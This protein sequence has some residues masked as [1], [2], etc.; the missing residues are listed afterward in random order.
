[1]AL[2][3]GAK[4]RLIE[5]L[6]V[7]RHL[8]PRAVEAIY[9]VEGGLHGAIGDQGTSFGP[10]QMHIGGAMPSGIRNPQQWANSRPGLKY[11]LDHIASVARGLRGRMAVTAIASKFERPADVQGEI[12]K[13]MSRYGHSP[14]HGLPEPQSFGGTHGLRAR[15]PEGNRA[16]LLQAVMAENAAFA[17][18][19]PADPST[20]TNAI[21]AAKLASTTGGSIVPPIDKKTGR[22]PSS[23]N[24]VV[25]QVL[26]QAHRQIG[27]P[28]VWGGESRKEGGFD[29]SGLIQ[30]AYAQAG[31][32]IPRTTY[33]Q[34]KVGKHVEWGH[35]KPGDLIFAEGGGHVVMYVGHGKVI[36]APHTGAVVRYQPVTD[37]KSTFVGAR[38][39]L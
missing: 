31:V 23:G 5:H 16:A 35:F 28:Y 39:I 7:R 34:I 6:A 37:F 25:D 22:Y 1:M 24:G 2:S 30:W 20:F 36:A 32:K 38:R 17:Q 8:D 10:F 3:P 4:A 29:C 26:H 19:Q 27:Q 21:L 13:A 14:V 33:E 11:A 9:S 12:E 18:G 15:A